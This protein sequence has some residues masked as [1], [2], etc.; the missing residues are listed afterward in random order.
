[1]NRGFYS[2]P[3]PREVGLKWKAFERAQEKIA[4]VE[5]RLRDVKRRRAEAEEQIKR[6]GDAE[7]SELA[8][9]ILEGADDPVARHDEHEKLVAELRELRRQEQALTQ[10]LPQTEE[11]LRQVVY[12]NQHRWKAEADSALEKAIQEE[13]KAYDKALQL[14]EEPRR[15]RIYA[16]TLAGWVRYPSPTFG[17]PSDVAAR[18]AM[19]NLGSGAYSAEQKMQ[20]RRHNEQLQEQQ[21]DG[22]A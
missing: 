12:E 16:E 21:Q 5:E 8:R 1:M 14:I 3:N 2:L 9:A 10:A 22:A 20:E 13:R 15:R 4:R 7:V 19:Q 11:E 6:L 17:E 18:S